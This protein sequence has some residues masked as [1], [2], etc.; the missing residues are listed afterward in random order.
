MRK[1]VVNSTPLIALAQADML[2]ILKDLYEEIMIPEA[3]FSEITVKDD[4]AREMLLHNKSWIKVHRIQDTSEKKMYRSR[5]HDGEVEVMILAK[6]SQADLVIID[7]YAAR[8]TAQYLGLPLTGTVG[9][10]L[11]AKKLGIL[12][13]VFPVVV[14]MER[15]GIYFSEHLK[16]QI[17]HISGEDYK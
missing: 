5:L 11:K 17:A 1:V 4:V 15:N 8:K 16:E 3:V 2:H 13:A 7:D 10:L 12:E 14:R 6:E 9:V